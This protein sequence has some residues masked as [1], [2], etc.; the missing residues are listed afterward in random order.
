MEKPTIFL[1]K[2]QVMCRFDFK[3]SGSNTQILNKGEEIIRIREEI[4]KTENRQSIEKIDK[5][6]TNK[7]QF[8]EKMNKIEKYLSRLT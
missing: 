1:L 2:G 3:T 4:N 7:K 6:K 8:F 5:T